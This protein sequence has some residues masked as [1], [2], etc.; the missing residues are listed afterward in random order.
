MTKRYEANPLSEVDRD[1]E[2]FS[3][4]SFAKKRLH[5]L[6]ELVFLNI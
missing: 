4:A 5:M 3:I 2:C 6:S 1:Q